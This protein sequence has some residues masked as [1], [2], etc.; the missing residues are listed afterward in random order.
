MRSVINCAVCVVCDK[1][2]LRLLRRGLRGLRRL[3]R[4]LRRRVRCGLRGCGLRRRDSRRNN[5]RNVRCV[6][7]GKL[8]F[9]F[10]LYDF[11]DHFR[12]VFRPIR[13]ILAELEALQIL[14]SLF[15]LP[16]FSFLFFYELYKG[17]VE[18][19]LQGLLGQLSKPIDKLFDLQKSCEFLKGLKFL[20]DLNLTLISFFMSYTGVPSNTFGLFKMP[21]FMSLALAIF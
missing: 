19:N 3:R 4:G 7:A 16:N 11:S 8:F 9:Y 10:Y 2:G 1:C 20:K 17:A 15:S 12:H 13:A 6:K 14:F 18:Y 21:I 5:A